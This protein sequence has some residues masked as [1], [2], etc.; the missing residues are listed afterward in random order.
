MVLIQTCNNPFL[1]LGT[2]VI[3]N[4]WILEEYA[5]MSI[6]PH[7]PI[8]PHTPALFLMF[9]L[10][11]FPVSLTN[12]WFLF[13]NIFCPFFLQTFQTVAFFFVAL[14]STLHFDFILLC[15]QQKLSAFLPAFVCMLS[16]LTST[17]NVS[18]DSSS[19]LTISS[20]LA[21]QDPE[22]WMEECMVHQKYFLC[23]LLP[24]D[25]WLVTS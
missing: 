4:L 23:W 25:K 22:C 17:L 3:K 6:H 16:L 15:F 14:T 18:D 11:V 12:S 13:S 20:I 1:L 10:H 7:P 8:H 24:L 19:F 5:L 21:C 9:L 2:K